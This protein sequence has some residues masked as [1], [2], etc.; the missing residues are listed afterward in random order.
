MR[1]P[2]TT[3]SPLCELEA[4]DPSADEAGSVGE[5]L[6]TAGPVGASCVVCAKAGAANTID[7]AMIVDA[8]SRFLESINMYMSPVFDDGVT[9]LA[10]DD[11]QLVSM[12]TWA[13]Q[14]GLRI[15]SIKPPKCIKFVTARL[16]LPI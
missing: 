12:E 1:E 10:I 14:P 13:H 7:P 3:M 8:S 11:T 9:L 4:L 5:V 6:G 16:R 2:V 15:R